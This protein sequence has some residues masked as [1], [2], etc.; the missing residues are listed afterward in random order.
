MHVCVCA[1][2]SPSREAP[3]HSHRAATYLP[4]PPKLSMKLKPWVREMMSRKETV[5][6]SSLSLGCRE[7]ASVGREGSSVGWEGA[8]MGRE[9]ASVGKEGASVGREG[10][11]VGREGSSVGREG[12]SMG[13]EGASMGREGASVGR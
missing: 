7:G 5:P 3:P 10:A 11:S 13:R 12:A 8:S 6:S 4:T 2:S 1:I 9:G